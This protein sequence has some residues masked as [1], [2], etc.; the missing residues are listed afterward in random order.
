MKQPNILLS[1]VSCFIILILILILINEYPD[2]IN[3][4]PNLNKDSVM[5][6]FSKT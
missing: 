2:L 3:E 1:L 5:K 4:Y 6:A